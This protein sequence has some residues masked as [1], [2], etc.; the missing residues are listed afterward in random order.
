M[1]LE[2]KGRIHL[3]AWDEVVGTFRG[4]EKDE[5]TLLVQFEGFHFILNLAS[6][7]AE[8]VEK[9][10]NNKIGRKIG[11]LRTDLVEKPFIAREIVKGG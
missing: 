10:L 8:I 5:F 4:L 1:K 2:E 7:E 11:L 6:H 9:L 3:K